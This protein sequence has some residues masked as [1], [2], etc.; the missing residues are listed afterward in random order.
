MVETISSI[1]GSHQKVPLV[2]QLLLFNVAHS[3]KIFQVEFE[4]NFE[5]NAEAHVR[6]EKELNCHTH[7]Q[8][9]PFW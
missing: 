2:S 6:Q 9:Q 7:T 4:L 5:E 8:K 3:Y 1:S